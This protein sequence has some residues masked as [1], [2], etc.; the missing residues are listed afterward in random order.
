[1]YMLSL[2]GKINL[3]IFLGRLGVWQKLWAYPIAM[4][5]SGAYL[6]FIERWWMQFSLD[7]AKKQRSRICTIWKTGVWKSAGTVTPVA[8]HWLRHCRHSMSCVSCSSR[9]S[10]SETHRLKRSLQLSILFYRANC[11]TTR[12]TWIRTFA[13]GL[14]VHVFTAPKNVT[15]QQD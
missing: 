5:H 8:S 10:V 7:T 11:A 13:N 4:W 9:K 12:L 1:M 3:L 14:S 2:F 6:W 15:P